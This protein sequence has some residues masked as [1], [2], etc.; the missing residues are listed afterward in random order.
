MKRQDLGLGPEAGAGPASE[1]RE[2]PTVLAVGDIEEWRRHGGDIPADSRLAFTDF[3]SVTPE[4]FQVMAPTLVLSPLLAR[5]FD[6]IDLSQVLHALGFKGR[7]R[8][9]AEHL[10]DPE[11]IR[12]EI[13]GLCPGLDFDVIV[14][15]P[16]SSLTH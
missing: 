13:A 15:P 7:Y 3:G 8:A 11:M 2:L 4:L 1:N 16:R 12:R 9:I 14:M 5:G 10:P 6:C